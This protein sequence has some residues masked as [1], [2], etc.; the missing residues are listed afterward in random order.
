[1]KV[2]VP[3]SRLYELLDGGMGF[4]HLLVYRRPVAWLFAAVVGSLTEAFPP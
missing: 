2:S 3:L 4:D 1:M